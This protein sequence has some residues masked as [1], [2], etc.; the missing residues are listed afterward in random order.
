[1]SYAP[2]CADCPT[3][4]ECKSAND[5]QVLRQIRHPAR[6]PSDK[7]S[8][9]TEAQINMLRPILIESMTDG[10]GEY[11]A[12]IDTLCDMAIRA[13]AALHACEGMDTIDLAS[14]EKGWLADVALKAAGV[15]RE[16]AE[17]KAQR[18]AWNEKFQA[19]CAKHDATTAR[20]MKA[21]R[22][23]LSADARTT[24]ANES[25]CKEILDS[26][27]DTPLPTQEMVD[28]V[29]GVLQV[30]RGKPGA[31]FG[32]VRTHCSLRGDDLSR[33]PVWIA[34]EE[35]Q[36]YVNEQA[37]ACMV[38]E[39]M[40][41]HAPSTSIS[42]TERTSREDIYRRAFILTLAEVFRSGWF[43]SDAAMKNKVL[44]Y[45][46]SAPLNAEEYTVEKV[47]HDAMGIPTDADRAFVEKSAV[48]GGTSA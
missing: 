3:P 15:E 44:A 37:A 12:Q 41:R 4:N 39:I 23:A 9:L 1:M 29:R 6:A 31:N 28:A 36:S 13:Q 26:S 33:W 46:H 21:D 11:P 17:A 47:L 18:D 10:E 25:S 14:N 20:A 30:L 35:G 27:F 24:G 34:D 5:C 40:Q 32:D 45:L 19:E 38:Y 7:T 2:D 43:N 22:C 48:D 16:L 42:A 8:A